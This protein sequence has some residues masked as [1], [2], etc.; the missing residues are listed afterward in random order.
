M[1]EKSDDP[2][3][4]LSLKI[5]RVLPCLAD[6]D[7][8]RFTA[9]FDGDVSELFPYLNTVLRGAVY[10]HTGKTLTIRKEGRLITLHPRSVS[11]GKIKDVA[12]ARVIIGWIIRLL[13]EIQAKKDTIKPTYERHER[14][15]VID[16][17]KLLPGDNCRKCGE[18]TCLSFAAALAMERVSVMSCSELFLAE[19]REKRIELFSLLRAGGY[20]VPDAFN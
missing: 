14:L 6:P 16:I 4:A 1:T 13:K 12:D 8:I 9:E 11:A 17:V 7:K 19:Y 18:Q 10:N 20:I 15:Q 2:I 5:V 3:F